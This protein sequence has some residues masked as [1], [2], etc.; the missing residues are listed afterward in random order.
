MCGDYRPINQV[1]PHDKYP[2]PNS[3]EIFNDL[4]DSCMFS[5]L[6]LKKVQSN[7]SEDAKQEEDYI[8]Q[9]Q[10]TLGVG[11]HALWI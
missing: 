2:M 7:L 1:V 11:G 4:Y 5:I 10:L 8:S 9:L 3:K 6:D